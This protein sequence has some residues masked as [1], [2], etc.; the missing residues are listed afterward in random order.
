MLQE[1]LCFKEVCHGL[2]E[3]QKYGTVEAIARCLLGIPDV[4]AHCSLCPRKL[5]HLFHTS[6][7]AP[8]IPVRISREFGWEPREGGQRHMCW[9]PILQRQ[10][11]I[12]C[13]LQRV[14]GDLQLTRCLSPLLGSDKFSLPRSLHACGFIELCPLCIA[15]PLLPLKTTGGGGARL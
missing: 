2:W 11:Y 5:P 13:A 3:V 7:L 8:G 1:H 9:A 10:F 4:Y 15:Q 14:T 12:C 6:L